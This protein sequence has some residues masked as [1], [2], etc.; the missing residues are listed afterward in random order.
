M[1]TK[2]IIVIMALMIFSTPLASADTFTDY[3][4]AVL[5][6]QNGGTI[7]N[8]VCIMPTSTPPVFT[9]PTPTPTP[10]VTT[11]VPTP[12]PIVTTPVPTPI[13]TPTIPVYT[14]TPPNFGDFLPDVMGFLRG[15]FSWIGV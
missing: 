9:T 6:V 11:P 14:I 8:G 5:C 4:A 7:V 12:T 10:I 2:I 3:I 13:P 15:L 1:K